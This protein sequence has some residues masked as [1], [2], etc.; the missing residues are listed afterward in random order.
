MARIILFTFSHYQVGV[1]WIY[2]AA[3]A[4]TSLVRRARLPSTGLLVDTLTCVYVSIL[5]PYHF[6]D[7]ICG[8]MI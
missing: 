8:I 7:I 4:T 3:E 2:A 5:T 1:R 6:P